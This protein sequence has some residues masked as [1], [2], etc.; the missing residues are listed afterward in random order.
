PSM[1]RQNRRLARDARYGKYEDGPDP[2]APPVDQAEMVKQH[3]GL[4]AAAQTPDDHRAAAAVRES[5]EELYTSLR[6]T[7]NYFVNTHPDRPVREIVL[8]GG[9]AAAVAALLAGCSIKG[10]AASM[11]PAVD[12]TA[13]WK[14]AK[15]T[16]ELNFANW[17]LY[18]DSDH[19][20][21]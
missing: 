4:G 10:S 19:G 3:L 1:A 6:N 14:D 21:S 13:F 18:I 8:A 7:V 17:P 11:G 2:L 16:K 12:W 20:K 5:V 9:G 15:P